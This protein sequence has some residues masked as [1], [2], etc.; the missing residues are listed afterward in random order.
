MKKDEVKKRMAEI[1]LD[2]SLKG[3]GCIA[4]MLEIIDEEGADLKIT[5]AYEITGRKRNDSGARVERA[6]RHAITRYYQIMGTNCHPDLRRKSG[7]D[8]RLHN[9]EFL[10]RLHKIIYQNTNS[11][12]EEASKRS[13]KD[14]AATALAREIIEKILL[15][16]EMDEDMTLKELIKKAT[17]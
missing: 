4:D 3:F 2:I 7:K 14:D 16:A 5:A 12:V 1:G 8:M 9:K 13:A 6:I 15:L 11:E 10:A 17:A